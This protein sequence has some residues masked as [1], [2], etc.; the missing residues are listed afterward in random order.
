MKLSNQASLMAVALATANAAA[1]SSSSSP[2]TPRT[3]S[4]YSPKASEIAQ[5]ASNAT[6]NHRTSNVSGAATNRVVQIWLENT[7]YDKAAGDESLAW[8]A[9]KGITLD[10]Y[11][12]LTHPSEPNYLASVAGDYFALNDDRFIALPANVSTVVDLLD[13]K[14]ISWAEYQ[15]HQPYTGFQGFNYSNQETFANDYVRKHNPLMLFDS[16][17]NDADRLANIKNFT[18]F[19][20]DLNGSSLPQWSFITPN[21]TNDGHDTTIKFA[22]AWARGFLEP[23][24][25]NEY[26]MENTLVILTF[27]ENE[28]YAVKNKV[29]TILLG[30]S[31]PESLHGT[32]DST[33]YDHYSLLSS[34]EANW[35]LPSLGRHDVDANVFQL[36]A[37]A[38]NIT[39]QVVDT[40]YKVNNATYVGYL[41]DDKI[42]LPAPNVTATNKNGKG[43]LQKIVSVWSSDYSSQ[44]SASYFTSTTT[45]Q[46]VA[47]LTDVATLVSSNVERS[48]AASSTSGSMSS[49]ATSHANVSS[50]VSHGG[51]GVVGLNW[52]SMLTLLIASIFA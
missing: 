36:I 45:T 40:T 1:S 14:N 26:F 46:S 23:L 31:I 10:N 47:S 7:D 38:T 13:T 42:A 16:I 25:S 5:H 29:F 30:G 4:M 37:N 21:M 51:S 49:R 12:A 8:L 27:D 33:Y 44:A 34:V 50:S 32:T 9:T 39:N 28:T 41:L 11:W 18:E 17:T 20:H 3:Y 15:E 2:Y 52:T 48:A 19:Y 6:T 24:L 22:G 43:V 35:N